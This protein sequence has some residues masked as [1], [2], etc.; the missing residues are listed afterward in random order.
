MQH[1]GGHSLFYEKLIAALVECGTLGLLHD[2]SAVRLPQLASRGSRTR[3]RCPPASNSSL[4]L[5]PS[6]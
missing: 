3:R 1:F 5:T 2:C 6:W 4:N